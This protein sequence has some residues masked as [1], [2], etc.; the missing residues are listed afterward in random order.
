MKKNLMVTMAAALILGLGTGFMA[1]AGGGH[2]VK[3]K[4]NKE[5]VKCATAEKVKAN[6]DCAKDKIEAG[7]ACVKDK[8]EAK[9]AAHEAVKEKISA[10]KEN[11]EAVKD[12]VNN[13]IETRRENYVDNRQDHQTDRIQHGINRGYLTPEETQS[14]KIQQQEIAAL[15]SSYRS[16]GK[17]SMPEMKDLQ[18]A[19]NV[20]SANIWAEKHDTDGVQMATYRLGKDVFAKSSFTSQM[21]N[22]DMTGADAKALTSDFRKMLG[23]KTSLANDNLSDEERTQKQTEYNELLNKYFEV[24]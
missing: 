6:K 7:K 8:I 19:L 17:L 5:A 11:R 21:A 9:K 20:A 14:L 16:D 12:K 2:V 22:Q 3:Q 10:N 13:K 1:E 15:E 4:A 23:L 18:S 24:R